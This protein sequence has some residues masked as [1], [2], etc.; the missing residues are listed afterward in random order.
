MEEIT[1]HSNSLNGFVAIKGT[2]MLVYFKGKPLDTYQ[3]FLLLYKMTMAW[4]ILVPEK[5]TPNL[6][7]S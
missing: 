7:F 2:F 1:A 3:T 4:V 6:L 5:T